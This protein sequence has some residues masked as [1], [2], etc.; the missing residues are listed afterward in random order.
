[1]LR[2]GLHCPS[3][4]MNVVGLPL[5]V[6]VFLSLY[7]TIDPIHTQSINTPS[8]DS[9]NTFAAAGGRHTVLLPCYRQVGLGSV[10]AC[11]TQL[12]CTNSND[13]LRRVS[14]TSLLVR[15]PR[16]SRLGLSIVG[17]LVHLRYCDRR[18]LLKT[19][20]LTLLLVPQVHQHSA[21]RQN[22]TCGYCCNQA[23]AD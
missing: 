16:L 13:L 20:K 2:S 19:W 7:P 5:L 15:K 4:R 12:F 1:L 23:P 21:Q 3:R 6:R 14:G 10:H 9:G 22:R 8:H 17:R 11:R 18:W